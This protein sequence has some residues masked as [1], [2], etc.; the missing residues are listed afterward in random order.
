MQADRPNADVALA[1]GQPPL[2][3][4]GLRSV[5]SAP[6]EL[7]KLSLAFFFVILGWLVLGCIE[8]DTAED[9]AR[10]SVISYGDRRIGSNWNTVNVCRKHHSTSKF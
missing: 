6:G 1:L 3:L 4:E 7:A 2:H 10:S 5:S 9:L 8:S